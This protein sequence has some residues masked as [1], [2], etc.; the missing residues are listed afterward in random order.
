M[1][2]IEKFGCATHGLEYTGN[3]HGIN[4]EEFYEIN[5]IRSEEPQYIGNPFLELVEEILREAENLLRA[6]HNVPKIGEGWVSEMMIFDLIRAVFCEAQ[7]HA[8]PE[9]LKPQHLD[10]F[11]PSRKLA[12]EYQGRQHFEPVDFF[13]GQE[14]LE[15]TARLDR[16]KARKCRAN[17]VTLIQWLYTEPIDRVTLVEK[18]TKVGI[19]I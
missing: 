15:N 4:G 10:V 8:S 12:F 14:S 7:H 16:L 18:L 13:G 19:S 3:K 17:G 5:V 11:V 1:N 6:R 2:E 9:W